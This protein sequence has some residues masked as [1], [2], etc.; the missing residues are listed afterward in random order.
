M[1]T[2]VYL[3]LFLS[4]NLSISHTQTAETYVETGDKYHQNFENRLAL[5]EYEKAYEIAP[6]NYL[7][8]QR[9]VLTSNDYGED[10][11]FTD[12]EKAKEYFKKSVK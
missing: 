11:R 7:I 5:I 8:L 12:M 3:I 10:L 9:L 6:D 4:I 2:L 1:K